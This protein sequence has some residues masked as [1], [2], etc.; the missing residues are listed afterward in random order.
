[1]ECEFNHTP[2][3]RRLENYSGHATLSLDVAKEVVGRHLQDEV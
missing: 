1:M 2:Y 3:K